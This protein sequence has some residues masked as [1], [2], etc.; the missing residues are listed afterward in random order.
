MKKKVHIKRDLQKLR[1][2][3]MIFSSSYRL[4]ANNSLSLWLLALH[5]VQN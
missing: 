1:I 2:F 5:V 3:F 4:Y